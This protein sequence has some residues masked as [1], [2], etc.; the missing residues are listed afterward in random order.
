MEEGEEEREEE[1]E[2]GG[3]RVEDREGGKRRGRDG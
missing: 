1:R 2:E 3:T